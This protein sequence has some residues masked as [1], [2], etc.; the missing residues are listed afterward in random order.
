MDAFTQYSMSAI[1]FA[2][3]DA[4]LEEWGQKRPIGVI[5]S[6]LY[7]CLDTDFRYFDTVIPQNGMLASP[8]LFAYTLASSFLGEVAI[9]FGLD[10]PSYVLSETPGSHQMC[11]KS[12]LL[13]LS[14]GECDTLVSGVSDL[15]CPSQLSDIGQRKSGFLYFVIDRKQ[16]SSIPHYGK[17]TMDQSG[18]ILFQDRIIVDFWMLAGACLKTFPH[19]MEVP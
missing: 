13:S 1:A 15:E 5:A 16:R 9:H 17:L 12:T 18:H 4:G 19:S 7:G 11:L 3:R 2:L 14:A 10:G 8:H 6:S